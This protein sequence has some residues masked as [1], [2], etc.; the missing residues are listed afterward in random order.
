M[1]A[2]TEVRRR[3][4]EDRA[5]SE[6]L[7]ALVLGLGLLA[8]AAASAAACPAPALGLMFEDGFEALSGA[9]PS[10]PGSFTVA[11]VSGSSTRAGRTTPWVAHYPV[12]AGSAPLLLFA[13]GF[14]IPSS[15]YRDWHEHLASW[16]FIAVRA[17]PLAG[18]F[19]PDHVAMA[20]D[21]RQVLSDMRVPG[22]LP[23]G[24]DGSRLALAGHSLGGKLALM[25]AGGDARVGALILLDP[26]NGAGPFGYSSTQPNIVPQPVGSIGIPVA[27]LGELLDSNAGN[28]QA[29]APAAQNYQIL[30]NA[31]S[32]APLAYEWTLEGA[33]HTS[34][35]TNPGQCGFACDLCN[36]PTRPL[37]QTHAFMRASAVAFLR[38]H[39]QSEQGMCAWLTGARVPGFVSTRMRASP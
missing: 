34:F 18:G 9:D 3:C 14:Q 11:S 39:W 7:R 28:G 10:A 37:A 31:L 35:V 25:A 5:F 8:A 1:P 23:V 27:M 22:A 36:A 2:I 12:Q 17:D 19:S 6:A 20:L 15:A 16:G 38:S 33:S 21:L 24:V 4:P 26:V 32:A 29:C 30:F 13:P